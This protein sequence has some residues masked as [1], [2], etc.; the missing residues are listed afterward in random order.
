M[1]IPTEVIYIYIC[2]LMCEVVIGTDHHP[3]AETQNLLV[4]LNEIYTVS[5]CQ[6]ET[7]KNTCTIHVY[8]ANFYKKDI[9]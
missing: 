1:K 6:A 3:T 4:S 9:Q 2:T 8:I 7:K 5:V